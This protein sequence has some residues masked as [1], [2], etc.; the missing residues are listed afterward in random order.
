MGYRAVGMHPQT[1]AK[2]FFCIKPTA[3]ELSRLHNTKL[4]FFEEIPFEH[5]L[6]V[7]TLIG[8]RAEVVRHSR[9][10]FSASRCYAFWWRDPDMDQVSIRRR[11]QMSLIAHYITIPFDRIP[12]VA[13]FRSNC[14]S[15]TTYP[16]SMSRSLS[17]SPTIPT[18][19]WFAWNFAS[20]RCPF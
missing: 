4:Q 10:L 12:N 9:I 2:R 17:R 20:S 6:P 14:Q 11:T 13:T 16:G 3:Y 18:F 7:Q 1:V 8:F 15:R 19:R 5:A